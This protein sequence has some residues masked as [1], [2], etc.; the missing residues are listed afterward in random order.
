MS[1]PTVLVLPFPAQGHVNPMVILSEKLVE[2]GCNVIFVNTEF[3]HK[4]VM[5]SMV[6]QQHS[7]DKSQIKLVSFPDGLGPDDDRNNEKL[8]DAVLSSMP[9]SLEKL[10]EDI[11]L[12]GENKISFLVADFFMAWAMDVA[13]KF[14]I[15]GA[16]FCPCSAA[17]FAAAYSIPKLLHDGILN[18]DGL[19]ITTTKAIQISPEMPELDVRVLCWLR[20]GD[21]INNVKPIFDLIAHCARSANLTEWWLCDTTYEFEPKV[22]P[23]FPKILP[24]G[25][26]LRSY[27]NTNATPRSLGQFWEED[28]SCMNWLDQQPHGSVTYVAFGSFTLFDQNQFNELAHAL[29]L[30]NKPFLWV[31]RQDNKMTFPSNFH[32][33]KGKIVSWAP[34]QKVLNHHVISCFVTHCGWNSTMEGLSNG[35]PLLCWPYFVDQ[36]YNK[37]LI[38]DKLNVG[39]DLN[40]NENGLVS[41]WEIKKK[42]D[43]LL[44]DEKIR[45]RSLKLKE[46]TREN[47]GLS[48]ENINKFVKWL[49]E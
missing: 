34:Q 11:H 29:D 31:V 27:E 30:T 33:H 3:N 35:V 20:A 1:V 2:Q 15:K 44:A 28:L 36:F 41:R 9:T 32:G 40:S 6:E 47:Q 42:L 12:E 46:K 38:C 23:Y 24:I 45:T 14:G 25:P 8:C 21:T 48:L 17:V 26:L 39:I 22:L 43:E 10:I 16:I 49:K 37:I 19:M 18:S 5:S 7:L 4:R 13:A